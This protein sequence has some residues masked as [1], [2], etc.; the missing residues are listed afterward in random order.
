V[1]AIS[2]TTEGANPAHTQFNFPLTQDAISGSPD[3]YLY[4]ASPL[5]S[6]MGRF[7]NDLSFDVT[8]LAGSTTVRT[9]TLYG[10]EDPA[11]PG[12]DLSTNSSIIDLVADINKALKK[13]GLQTLDTDGNIAASSL[14]RADF[15]GNRLLFTGGPLVTTFSIN[16]SSAVATK[17]GLTSG[18]HASDADDLIIKTN[19]GSS[20]RI[21]LDGATDVGDIIQRIVLGT[22]GSGTIV[23]DGSGTIAGLTFL[24]VKVEFTDDRSG[25]KLTDQTGLVGSNV[26]SIGT[27]NGSNAALDLRI[28]GIEGLV[29][30]NNDGVYD[31]KDNKDIIR[32]SDPD[33]TRRRACLGNLRRL[34]HDR[35]RRHRF[36][37]Y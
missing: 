17:L 30:Q 35:S 18:S 9:I 5:R 11:V 12:I 32:R 13:A 3:K 31:A 6:S 21:S 37:E 33:D 4:A 23:K 26:F 36:C 14:L 20:S 34:R 25:L 19:D 22:G 24:K 15:I 8:I 28:V 2:L 16:P 1:T 27:I 7:G 10:S 29:D